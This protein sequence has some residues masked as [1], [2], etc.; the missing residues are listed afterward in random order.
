MLQKLGKEL[1]AVNS[2]CVQLLLLLSCA[3]YNITGSYIW[4]WNIQTF[5]NS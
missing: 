2:I 3:S 1:F 5:E 4:A